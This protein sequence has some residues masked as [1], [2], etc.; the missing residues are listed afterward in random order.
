MTIDDS[1]TPSRD[2][3][4]GPSFPKW[5]KRGM[6]GVLVILVL[7]YGAIFLSTNVFNDGP[8]EAD[9]SDLDVTLSSGDGVLNGSDPD[10]DGDGILNGD[11]PDIDGDGILNGDDSDIDGDGIPN[12][13]D[14]DLDADGVPEF[15]PGAEGQC[16]A[17]ATGS[18]PACLCRVG[19]EYDTQS[20]DCIADGVPEFGPGAEGQCPADA[21]G[22][23]PAC[24]CRVGDE[25]DTQSNDC[26]AD[27][28]PEFGPGAEGQCPA[29]AT[30]SYPACLC[31]V[32]EEYDTQSNDC[33]VSIEPVGECT[34]VVINW[35]AKTVKLGE[36]AE[37]SWSFMPAGCELAD[38]GAQLTLTVEVN[39]NSN[40]PAESV[41]ASAAQKRATLTLPCLTDRSRTLKYEMTGVDEAFGY[42]TG[43]PNS[44]T[45]DHA[46]A[47]SCPS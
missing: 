20:N 18:Y 1:I 27:G 22:S 12:G 40:I 32:G 29:D 13:E 3:D 14:P 4:E 42:V 38:E 24:L 17:D 8:D 31:R 16:P 11:D 46:Q 41:F 2:A 9:K 26:I 21:T 37:V 15:G 45:Q 33:I 34:S 28:V 47:N 23:Y 5:L 30:G 10:I 43:V 7:G 35:P 25:Y 36:S 39:A 44:K 6:I 19:D